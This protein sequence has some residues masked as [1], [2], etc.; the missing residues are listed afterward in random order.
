[1]NKVKQAK[2][3]PV[4]PGQIVAIPGNITAFHRGLLFHSAVVIRQAGKSI[5]VRPD[6]ELFPISVPATSINRK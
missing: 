5:V 4:K 1:M 6:E 2:V 3:K